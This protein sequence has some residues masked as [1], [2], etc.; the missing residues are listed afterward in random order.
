MM[1]PTTSRRIAWHRP[2]LLG[3]ALLAVLYVV[4]VVRSIWPPV[5]VAFLFAMTLDPV[6]DRLEN[7]GWRRMVATFLIFVLFL[8]FIIAALALFIPPLTRQTSDIASALGGLFP[9]SEHPGLVG[10][11]E[12]FLTEVHAPPGLREPIL[13]AAREATDRLSQSLEA[14]SLYLLSVAPNLIWLVIVPIL[15]FYALSDFHLIYAK[16]LLLVPREHRQIV[17]EITAEVSAVF[18]RYMRG[19]GLVCL[20]NGLATAIMLVSFGIPYPLIL[21]LLAGM[22]YAVPYVGPIVGIGLIALISLMQ[23]TLVG[24]LLVV[25][26]LIFINSVLFDQLITPRLLGRQVGLHPILSIIAFLAGN[27]LAGIPGLLLAVPVAA[28]LQIVILH[29]VPKLRQEL[30]LQSL[31]ALQQQVDATKREHARAEDAPL[32]AH[33]RLESV[34]EKV[35]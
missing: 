11:V 32:D 4:Y 1:E 33:Y 29:L 13:R 5:A 20:L 25:V 10:P 7:R 18:G 3:L 17:Q 27:A 14:V 19:L 15:T 8:A 22:L 21:A 6:V 34:I 9:D 30:E 28:S 24:M 2:L 12:R 16:A 35:E 26:V 23:G 31:G